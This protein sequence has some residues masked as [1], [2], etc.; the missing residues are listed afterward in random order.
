ML[1]LKKEPKALLHRIL[2]RVVEVKEKTKGGIYIPE[3]TQDK[4]TLA[5]E[6]GTV[7]DIGE[8][9]Y[10]K[11]GYTKENRPIQ[12]GDSV[13]F[14]RYGGAEFRINGKSHRILN[15][16]DIT[17]RLDPEDQLEHED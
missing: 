10:L 14:S 1:E 13:T 11:D 6:V 12:V 16:E 5:Q 4:E 8:T 17:L 2:V 7:V 15:D 3:T 9:A